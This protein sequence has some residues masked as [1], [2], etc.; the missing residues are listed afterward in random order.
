MRRTIAA[1]LLA[2]VAVAGCSSSGSTKTHSAKPSQLVGAAGTASGFQGMGLDPAQ[3]RPSFTLT[4]TKGQLFPF[5]QK[6]GGH[7][8]LLFFG[9]T[10]CPDVC[11]TTLFDISAAL[12]TLP[13]AVQK[14][15]YVVFVTTDVKRDTGAVLAKWLAN[16]T[17]GVSAQ[18]VG[19]RG[20]QV[21]IDA[22][23][24]AAHITLA[25]DDGQT[26]SAQV[27]LYGSDDYARVTYLQSTNE[28]QQ[29]AH[30]LPLVTKG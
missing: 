30:D 7:P 5:A 19:L 6:T 11:P 29:I 24:T 9:Y 2:L 20:T 23:Q 12:R 18:F 13:Q 28:Q 26:H 14:D 3:P 1:A 8:T 27:L 17:T 4:D 22:A 15:T 10:N 16:F 21:Q 25:E